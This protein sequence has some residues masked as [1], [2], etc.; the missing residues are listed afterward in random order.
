METHDII[1]MLTPAGSEAAHKL[2][3]ADTALDGGPPWIP[4]YA[5]FYVAYHDRICVTGMALA[6]ALKNDG[7][8]KN[9]DGVRWAPTGAPP[10]SLPAKLHVAWTFAM[11]CKSRGLADR[12]EIVTKSL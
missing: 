6:I 2:L 8:D 4:S 10:E 12:V 1:V 7:D 3:E 11:E 5:G 9:A